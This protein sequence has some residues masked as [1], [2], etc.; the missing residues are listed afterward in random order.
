[1]VGC[2]GVDNHVCQPC[3][4]SRD[5]VSTLFLAF[6]CCCTGHD[7]GEGRQCCHCNR[8][9]CTVAMEILD[10]ILEESKMT[11][12]VSTRVRYCHQVDGKFMLK[13]LEFAVGWLTKD[14][15]Q[16]EMGHLGLLAETVL[17]MVT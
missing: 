14:S 11:F 5:V 1:L 15:Y 10:R 3:L 8:E 6:G 4:V 2:D 7:D 13:L 17:D 12:A 9:S 16:C